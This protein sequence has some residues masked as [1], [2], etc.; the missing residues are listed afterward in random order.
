[1]L[2]VIVLVAW[3]LVLLVVPVV[4]L[5]KIRVYQVVLL[6]AVIAG[7][8][9]VGRRYYAA[10]YPHICV[11]HNSVVRVGPGEQYG[12]CGELKKDDSVIICAVHDGWRHVQKVVSWKAWFQGLYPQGWVIQDALEDDKKV[13]GS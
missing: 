9:V 5:K 10:R 8:V 4:S 2:E 11:V 1:M 6:S 3:W 12:A 7:G 13:N